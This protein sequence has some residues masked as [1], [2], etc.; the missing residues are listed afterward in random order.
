M[1]SLWIAGVDGYSRGAASRAL[2]LRRWLVVAMLACTV[3][4]AL[5]GPGTAAAQ[6]V[7]TQQP[8]SVKESDYFINF[9]MKGMLGDVINANGASAGETVTAPGTLGDVFRTFNLGVSF[10]GAV[11][12]MFLAVIGIW[13]TG[14]DGEFLGRK[15]SSFMV[16]VRF[17]LGAV[18][19]LPVTNAG[20][21]FVQAMCLWITAQGVGFADNVWSSILT[22]VTRKTGSDIVSPV[23]VS[24]VVSNVMASKL[25]EA[26]YNQYRGASDGTQVVFK[27]LGPTVNGAN[28]TQVAGWGLAPGSGTDANDTLCGAMT[29]TW[30]SNDSQDPM[31][32]IR[33]QIAQAHVDEMKKLQ[34]NGVLGAAASDYVS[35]LF[36]TNASGA[37]SPAALA[38]AEDRIRAV[39]KSE[40]AVYQADLTAAAQSAINNSALANGAKMSASMDALGFAVAGAFY[41]ELA[42]VQNAVRSGFATAPTYIPVD[43]DRMVNVYGG[44][45]FQPV[46]SAIQTVVGLS[47]SEYSAGASGVSSAASA[48]GTSVQT[49]DLNENMFQG[50]NGRNGIAD[51]VQRI[52]YTLIN[53]IIGV[54]SENNT[55]LGSYFSGSNNNVIS[56]GGSQ[57]VNDNHS[58]IMQLKSKG[59]TILDIAGVVWGG[60]IIA[61]ATTAAVGGSLAGAVADK[62]FGG[63][64]FVA[65][66]LDGM[67]AFIFTTVMGLITLGVMLAVIIP[68]TPFML[69]VMG[70]AGLLILI[71]E[72]LVASMLWTVMLMH[73]SGDGITSDQSRNG[74]MILLNLFMRPSLMLMGMIG[75]IFMVDPLVDFVNDMFFFVFKSTQASSYTLLFITFGFISV[76]CTLVLSIVKRTFS[77][78]HVIPDTV[79]AWIGGNPHNLGMTDA[80]DKAENMAGAAGS[81]VSQASQAFGGAYNK[82]QSDGRRRA[83]NMLAQKRAGRGAG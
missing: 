62:V 50:F 59:D 17:A 20:Y 19:M 29:F 77:L 52:S 9:L 65:A 26:Y 25:C 21:S 28:S 31:T 38:A 79:L 72:S 33:T 41:M 16:P 80:A 63:V 40:A 10:F 46:M 24:S 34:T 27:T 2:E 43:S 71:I 3:M 54:G 14:Q 73:P 82:E 67:S 68:V 47:S 36:S 58:V 74:L 60:Y 13:Q 66:L 30:K 12:V 76:Y 64:S 75:G 56:N 4:V 61:K 53:S 35:L 11:V 48:N 44:A 8:F 15:W 51:G 55:R 39:I 49:I 70:I 6:A 78:I 45:N 37:V 69:W 57:F 18:L 81:R 7:P 5:F 83:M 1:T 42:K 32:P 22:N 23:S